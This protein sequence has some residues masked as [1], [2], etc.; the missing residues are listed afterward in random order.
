MT[1]GYYKR[2]TGWK[3]KKGRGGDTSA[4]S[5]QGEAGKE[6]GPWTGATT[7]RFFGD[8]QDGYGKTAVGRTHPDQQLGKAS[9]RKALKGGRGASD[10]LAAPKG[11]SLGLHGHIFQPTAK[12]YINSSSLRLPLNVIM[13]R[14]AEQQHPVLHCSHHCQGTTR[15]FYGG[16]S[17]ETEANYLNNYLITLSTP[18]THP[19]ST[20]GPVQLEL[21]PVACTVTFH[22]KSFVPPPRAKSS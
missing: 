5:A 19:I 1:E 12:S 2:I 17:K 9:G 11:H 18:P 21:P 3:G 20:L 22:A 16:K 15:A 10:P 8:R 6:T 13:G 14:L 4:P 7:P